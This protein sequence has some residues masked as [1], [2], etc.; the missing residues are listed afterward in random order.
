MQWKGLSLYR[1][2]KIG[3]G[4][5]NVNGVSAQ[6][7]QQQQYQTYNQLINQIIKG[8]EASSVLEAMHASQKNNNDATTT[9]TTTTTTIQE[10][11]QKH[12]DLSTLATQ[13]AL[14]HGFFGTIIASI[15]TIWFAYLEF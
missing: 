6:Q 2:S 8:D 3:N 14:L 4:S 7:Q 13:G 12:H 15:D 1:R 10:T 5:G 9:T 11:R